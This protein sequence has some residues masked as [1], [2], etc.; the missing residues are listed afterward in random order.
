[1]ISEGK[2]ENRKREKQRKGAQVI[3]CGNSSD[4]I[5]NT[6][7]FYIKA[8]CVII[9]LTTDLGF[10]NR[11]ILFAVIQFKDCQSKMISILSFHVT[12][13]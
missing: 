5:F 8:S 4:I 7:G 13:M 11:Y 12:N 3:R 10:H 1:M 9:L 6:L 2:K